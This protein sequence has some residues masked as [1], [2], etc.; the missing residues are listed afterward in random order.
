MSTAIWVGRVLH[1]T[2]KRPLKFY[3]FGDSI[4]FGQL[5]SAHETWASSLAIALEALEDDEAYYLVQNAGVNGNT[6]RQ[7]LERMHYDVLSHGPD[8]LLIQFGMNDCN[9]WKTDHGLPRVTREAFLA[10]LEEIVKKAT[11]AGV[12]HC[13]INTNHLSL[14]GEFELAID[15]N[16]DKSNADY[17][18]IIRTACRNL[19]DQNYPVTL[20]DIELEWKNILQENPQIEL[21]ELLLS[22]GIHLS[23]EG[24][25]VYKKVI[26][27]NVI[28]LIKNR[29]VET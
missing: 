26:N 22:D 10:N 1:K 28:R 8:Y 13:F 7:A 14:K 9:Y 18:D 11:H 29:L 25:L 21:Q 4:C 16:Y 5:V 17:N 12:R 24:H 20:L 19:V 23:R 3:I 2:N 6:T 27:E 15:I